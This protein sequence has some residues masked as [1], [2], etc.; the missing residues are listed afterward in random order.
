MYVSKWKTQA[1]PIIHFCTELSPPTE[2]TVTMPA[3]CTNRLQKRRHSPE[4][5]IRTWNFR[6]GLARYLYTRNTSRIKIIKRT[7]ADHVYPYD[8]ST[9]I[10]DYNKRIIF[11]IFLLRYL[12]IYSN[13]EYFFVKK[14]KK[15]SKKA[16]IF[17]IFSSSSAEREKKKGGEIL[18]RGYVSGALFICLGVRLV[19]SL[20]N[21]IVY[22]GWPF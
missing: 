5:S 11:L 1:T 3:S 13:V 19:I 20:G 22:I 2:I 18:I 8:S 16:T 10:E 14:K 9:R 12:Y 21:D 4:I 6:D 15:K 7:P 17:N